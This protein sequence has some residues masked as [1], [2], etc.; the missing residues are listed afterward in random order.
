MAY[1]PIHAAP[2]AATDALDA[3]SLVSE[4][5]FRRAMG[6]FATG[7]TVVSALWQHRRYAMTATAFASVSLEP[8]LVLL[9]V[10]RASRFHPV[11]LGAGEWAV[12]LLAADQEPV[13]RHFASSG[14]DLD[15]QFDAVPHHLAPVS[16]APV[17]DGALAWL[18]CQTVQAHDAGDHTVLIG[19]VQATGPE[20]VSEAVRAIEAASGHGPRL[21]SAAEAPLAYYRGTYLTVR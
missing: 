17:I 6:H 5:D 9:S 12:S 16:G 15:T 4:A 1:Q 11:V 21:E 3:G 8:P 7:V 14:R 20:R 13:A 2:A 19:R 18:D 10:G